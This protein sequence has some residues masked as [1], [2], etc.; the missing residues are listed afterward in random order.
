MR[1]ILEEKDG[2][3]EVKGD[4]PTGD[5][6]RQLVE[7][8]HI[9]PPV[10][11]SSLDTSTQR[12][13]FYSHLQDVYQ[14][15][16]E[17]RAVI[18]IHPKKK[19]KTST[20]VEDKT[21]DEKI[22]QLTDVI[23]QRKIKEVEKLFSIIPPKPLA[24]RQQF[25]S[26][27]RSINSP[28]A[29]LLSKSDEWSSY[30]IE[31]KEQQANPYTF[32]TDDEIKSK[33][34]LLNRRHNLITADENAAEFKNFCDQFIAFFKIAKII[35]D[36]TEFRTAIFSGSWQG[37]N[38]KNND[39]AFQ[40]AYMQLVLF[41][42]QKEHAKFFKPISEYLQNHKILH[43][44][45]LPFCYL[46]LKS[47]DKLIPTNKQGDT[48]DL[49]KW[50]ELIKNGG[51]NV[52][53][54]FAKASAIEKR[55]G[56]TP[57]NPAEVIKGAAK[58]YDHAEQNFELAT[59]C[60]THL[61][62]NADFQLALK[63]S[64]YK[65][66]YDLM[67][68]VQVDGRR[69]K[70][71]SNKV[72]EL[73]DGKEIDCSGYWIVKLPFTDPHSFVLGHL[74]ACCMQYGKE[75]AH[76]LETALKDPNSCM[77]VL[78]KANDTTKKEAFPFRSQQESTK[79]NL[80]DY[81][82]VGTYFSWLSVDGNLVIDS[83]ENVHCTDKYGNKKDDE[84]V[85]PMFEELGRQICSSPDSPILRLTIGLGGKTPKVYNKNKSGHLETLDYETT[86]KDSKKQ[87]EIYCDKDRL[88]KTITDLATIFC[89][90]LS[91]DPINSQ[92]I[93]NIF[94]N[95]KKFYSYKLKAGIIDLLENNEG[96]RSFLRE[97]ISQRDTSLYEENPSLCWAVLVQLNK[98]G[99]GRSNLF[100]EVFSRNT[101]LVGIFNGLKVIES[102]GSFGNIV[103]NA[104]QKI[105]NPAVIRRFLSSLKNGNSLH[106]KMKILSEQGLL[107]R[108]VNAIIINPDRLDTIS[109]QNRGRDNIRSELD[110]VF[111]IP[112]YNLFPKSSEIH[113]ERFANHQM[114]I[115]KSLSDGFCC[116]QSHNYVVD[117]MVNSAIF[118]E[119]VCAIIAGAKNSSDQTLNKLAEN[120]CNYLAL[121][122]RD[123]NSGLSE[124]LTSL[125]SRIDIVR[126]ILTI[127]RGSVESACSSV[128]EETE[129]KQSDLASVTAMASG[130]VMGATFSA[131]G[132]R[133]GTGASTSDLISTS[134]H[135][136]A[137]PAGSREE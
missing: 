128:R 70:V 118:T 34:K 78:L 30:N 85:I 81:R 93:K 135:H 4:Q 90:A 119:R 103:L 132:K 80:T 111:N 104:L 131:A 51:I 92:Q 27:L 39:L 100:A 98:L 61:M 105:E 117:Y 45:E 116:H 114:H 53:Q 16:F 47:F 38:D 134:A 42:S 126:S 115:L 23:E 94:F 75:G 64:Q 129:P 29:Y 88:E 67:P 76:Y 14:Y 20:K 102:S 41:G 127:N 13:H 95:S 40:M 11:A 33:F 97:R 124:Q 121:R 71:E 32:P 84:I 69:V 46:L 106:L 6:V 54:L 101:S 133:A 56:K 50:R 19:S 15:I 63:A 82:I 113:P 137:S 87:A 66:P 122:L 65:K 96:V 125:E 112:R 86:W 3:P 44:Q 79:L 62:T 130:Q 59:V 89:Q 8:D 57:S 48:F 5:Q 7:G 22:K 1:H 25:L 26:A 91:I 21:S 49:A 24:K 37:I 123:E 17:D 35:G 52:L 2:H 60:A 10:K 107:N 120:A 9:A 12:I 108:Y 58:L 72:R 74:S 99:L 43:N 36:F 73:V 28:L 136:T 18:S 109:L 68:A 77:Y 31:V 110:I 55:L 83:C